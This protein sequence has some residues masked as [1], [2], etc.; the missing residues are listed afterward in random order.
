MPKSETSLEELLHEIRRIEEHREQ[1]S[2]DKIK[3][4]YKTLM[5]DLKLFLGEAYEKYSDADGRLYLSYLD[6]QNKRAW[7]LNEIAKNC[8]GISP[9]LKKE[10]FDLVEETYSRTYSGMSEAVKTAVE[11]GG[12]AL[13]TQDIEVQP[14]I[15]NQAVNNNISKLTL[16]Q[17]MEKHRAEI[18]YQI[19]QELFIGLT[20]GDRYDQMAKRISERVGVS[21]SKA[22]NISRTESH[23]NTEAGFQDCAERIQ[24]KLE[25]S[26]LVYIKIYRTVKDERVRPQQR[27]KTKKGWKTT[28]SNN[29]ANHVDMEGTVK[30]VTEPFVYSDGSKC[31]SPGSI[32]L[33]ARHSCNCRCFSEYRLVTKEEYEKIKKNGGKL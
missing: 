20:R 8:N 22:M 14:D 10:M 7:F 6:A 3:A 24:E 17:V 12:L 33:P 5:R 19:Q 25:D 11:N 2:E 16:P 32:E 9:Q 15:L 31:M 18:I 13:A 28:Y 1:L 21:R 23:R 26:D 27:R 4:I 30:M 29:G